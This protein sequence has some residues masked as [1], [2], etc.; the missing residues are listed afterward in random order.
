MSKTSK[1]RKDAVPAA[2]FVKAYMEAFNAG[3]GIA[4]VT[5]RTGLSS[6]SVSTRAANYRKEHG[7]N[8]PTFERSGGSTLD[9][10]S[11][12]SLIDSFSE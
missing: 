1:T 11:L 4:G 3:E 12:K 10:D 2:V 9:I 7:L 6:G 5:Q 8:L